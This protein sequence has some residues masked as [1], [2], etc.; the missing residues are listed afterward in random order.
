LDF[1][2]VAAVISKKA[3][4]GNGKH[5]STCHLELNKTFKPHEQSRNEPTRPFKKFKELGRVDCFFY[6]TK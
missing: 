3:E 5:K 4:T 1:G 2:G 6:E